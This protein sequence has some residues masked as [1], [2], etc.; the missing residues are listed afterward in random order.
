MLLVRESSA[1]NEGNSIR[2]FMHGEAQSNGWTVLDLQNFW[3]ALHKIGWVQSAINSD[4]G[5]VG[6]LAYLLPD[7]KYS[8]VAPRGDVS[9]WERKSF[10]PD[11]K[12]APE[13]GSIMYFYV[14]DAKVRPTS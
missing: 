1:D 12:D 4:A 9:T 8:L 6:Q 11:F 5:D 10:T 3:L 14:R 13:G 7:Q 2:G